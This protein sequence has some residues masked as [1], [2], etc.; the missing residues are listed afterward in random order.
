MPRRHWVGR[1]TGTPKDKH[2]VNRRE[3]CEGLAFQFV[4][5]FFYEKKILFLGPSRRSEE[6]VQEEALGCRSGSAGEILS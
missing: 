4:F 1:G 6:G 5:L 2:E 3:V